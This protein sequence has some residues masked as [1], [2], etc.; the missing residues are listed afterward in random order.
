MSLGADLAHLEAHQIAEGLLE[1]SQA[2]SE[3]AHHLAALRRRHHPERIERLRRTVDRRAVLR[4]RVGGYGGQR[5]PGG[6]IDR[7]DGVAARPEPLGPDGAVRVHLD[8]ETSEEIL[9][10]RLRHGGGV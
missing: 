7:G 2:L 9:G 3:I 10:L 6:R 4:L 8:A 1:R 5:L